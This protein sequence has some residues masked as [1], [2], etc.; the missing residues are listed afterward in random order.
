VYA[1]FAELI[2]NLRQPPLL[3][4]RL[5]LGVFLNHDTISVFGH[6]ALPIVA[7]NKEIVSM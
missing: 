6:Y 5:L 3:A 4:F 2:I 1:A 7:M